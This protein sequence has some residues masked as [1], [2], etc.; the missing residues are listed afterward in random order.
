MNVELLCPF[1]QINALNHVNSMILNEGELCHKTTELTEMANFEEKC[2]IKPD[3][4]EETKK[5]F[6]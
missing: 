5:L 3:N 2:D 4:L 1:G 6:E